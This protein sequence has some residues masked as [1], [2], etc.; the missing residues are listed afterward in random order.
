MMI[1][2]YFF[3][4][5]IFI[6][7]C[8]QRIKV[9]INRMISPEV[10]G[11]GL[12]VQ[13]DQVGYSN[14]ILNLADGQNSPLIM[15][16]VSERALHLGIGIVDKLDIFMNIPKESSSRAGL[17][18]QLLGSPEKARSSGNKLALILATGSSTDLYTVDYKI[19][20]AAD[21]K[22]YALIHGYRFNENFLLY[23]SLS[24]TNYEFNGTI[25][26]NND[27]NYSSIKYTASN[28]FGVAV[29][30]VLGPPSL[31]VKGELAAQKVEWSNT[32]AKTS[33]SFGYSLTATW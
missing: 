11:Q 19:N 10:V 27:L 31:K 8:A 3:I 21:L 9:P 28:I 23:E 12:E 32:E 17:K 33:Y 15:S 29:G 13:Y 1:R 25:V 24:I 4:L 18:I 30:V 2:I 5:I 6:S 7:S 22:D 20:I 26:G 14:G 16:T